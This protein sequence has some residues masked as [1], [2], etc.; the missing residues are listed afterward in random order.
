MPCPLEGIRVLD[1]GQ[2]V[3][4]PLA[5]MLLGDMGAEVLRVDPPGGPRLQTPANAT[6]NRGK[7][8]I[9]LDLTRDEDRATARRLAAAADVLVENFR[10]GVMERLGLGAD[11]LLAENSRLIYC[12]LPGFATD[13]PRAGVPAWEGIVAAATGTYG[14]RL[15]GGATA[16]PL[17]TA[18]PISSC[19]GAFIGAVSTVMA[20]IARE[21]GGLGQRIEVPLFDATFTAIG[22]RGQ[23]VHSAGTTGLAGRVMPWVRQ[24]ECADGRWVQFHAANTRFIRQFIRAAGVEQWETEGFVDRT[25]LVD[26]AMAEEL[27]ARMTALFKTR[28]AQ[29]W[30]DLVNAA[31][32]P[33]AICRDSAEWLEHPHARGSQMIVEVQDPEHGRMLQPGINA[34]MS[35]TPGAVRPRPSGQSAPTG[36]WQSITPIAGANGSGGSATAGEI[37][38]ALHGVR[39]LDLCIIL[40]GPTCGRTLAEFGADVIKIDD[41]NREGGVAFHQDVNRGKRS[42]LLDLKTEAGRDVFWRLLEDADVV[43]QN[44]R[45][46]VVQ[47]LGLDYESVRARRPDVVYA[48]L[49]AYGHVGPWRDRPG[50]E[51]LAQ[52]ATGMQ[53]R[54]GGDGQP[55]LQPFPVNDYGTGLMGAYAVA[56]ALYHR[57]RTGEGQHVQTALAYTACTVQSLF[58]QD[59]DGKHWTEPRGQR[60]LGWS[61]PQR[62]YQAADGWFFLGARSTDADTLAK[63]VGLTAA[64]TASSELEQALEAAFSRGTL[65]EWTARLAAAGIAAQPLVDV[66]EL[67][68]DPWVRAHGLSLRRVHDGLGEV[69]TNGPAPRLSRTPVRPG[70]PA[71]RPGSDAPSILA[72][73]GQRD[74]LD[75]LVRSGIVRYDAVPAE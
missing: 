62:L 60:A 35:R 15:E 19:Y 61:P 47:R 56:L 5:A 73:A 57:K 26:P 49:N 59:Y 12:S 65:T 6:W 51:Q 20:L 22:V 3:A 30:E 18:V 66:A 54:Y 14:S 64:P 10:P 2:Y 16:Q 25:R 4:G 40:A 24:Y 70:D 67:M 68:A 74:V 69:T 46:G 72:E 1:F 55:V 21:R 29:E 42:I 8:T 58:L 23:I 33:T 71:P 38:S 43:V 11:A 9:E 63:L 45:D 75:A 34:R 17:I 44:Y 7:Q 41:P 37:L 31:G 50:W 36:G 28:S 52:A 39:V 48:S 53:K 13:D 32:T 27:L